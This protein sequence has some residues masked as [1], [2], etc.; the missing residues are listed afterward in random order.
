MPLVVIGPL[1]V[2]SEHECAQSCVCVCVCVRIRSL[3]LV[4]FLI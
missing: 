3:N 2:L 1:A 4:P